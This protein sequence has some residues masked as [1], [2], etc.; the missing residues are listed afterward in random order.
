MD[1]LA[2][3]LVVCGLISGT[4]PI[5]LMGVLIVMGGERPRA[6]GYAFLCGAFLIQTCLVFG[7][8]A[9]LGGRVD[10]LSN[11]GQSFIWIQFFLG[12]ALVVFGLL[13]R[14][15]PRKPIP[16]I[17]HALERLRALKPT[18][19]FVAGIVVADYQG[20]VLASL[21]LAASSVSISGRVAGLFLYASLATGI[22]LALILWTTR[23][24]RALQRFT[25]FTT[26]AMVHRR[27]VMS[28]ITI[29]VGLSV[30]VEA[31]MTLLSI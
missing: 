19:S 31:T 8:G 24:E 9:L 21:A 7:A 17:P 25:A 22:P 2:R 20:P 11:L 13:V 15:P 12:F 28:W 29:I 4:Q 30:I 23:S 16:E 27:A 1:D 10:P 26:K 5:T 18:Q 3:T 6:N 14:R